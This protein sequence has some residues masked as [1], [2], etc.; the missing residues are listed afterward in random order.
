MP[1]YARSLR[2]CLEPTVAPRRRAE[3]RQTLLEAC[4]VED[5]LG[6]EAEEE[7]RE[8]RARDKHL[9]S[10]PLRDVHQLHD[11][12]EDRSSGEREERDRERRARP[13]LPDDRAEERRS[14]ADHAEEREEPPAGAP[15]GERGHDAEPP[16][17][18]G[19]A[20]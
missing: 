12:V 17:R 14:A 16:R 15:A 4:Y 9:V 13:R 10:E 2:P 18:A 7:P 11:H 20:E 8:N 1:A 19:E 6:R 5:D 3:F